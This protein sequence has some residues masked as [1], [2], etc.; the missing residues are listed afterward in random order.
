MKFNLK[1]F[2]KLLNYSFKN[3]SLLI[4]ALTH[5]SFSIEDN[6]N[7]A[8]N[9]RLEF[10]G[11]SILNFIIAEELLKLF[12]E[13]QEGILSK[14]RASLVNLSK[15][16]SIA[17]KFELDKFMQFGPGEVKQGN[18]LNSRIQG[19]C[20]ESIIG[21][22][23]QDTGLENCRNW[24]LNQFTKDDFFGNVREGELNSGYTADYKSRLQE[25][26]QKHKLGTP[27]YNLVMTTGPSHKPQFLVS[28]M[29][30]ELEKARADG[31]SKKLAE[32]RA[33][34]LYL[35]ELMKTHKE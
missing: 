26:T 12:P 18:H 22:I 4:E 28:L 7:Q 2:Q 33:A 20:V 32:Q 27:I 31:S 9:E 16:A 3:E 1:E 17:I 34:E 24:I 10:L 29:L 19:S 23:Y 30:G 14:K 6:R 11:D 21:A 25:L 15:L 35:N 5:K 8:H 13:V